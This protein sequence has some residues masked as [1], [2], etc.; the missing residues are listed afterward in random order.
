VISVAIQGGAMR[1]V[2]CVGVIRAL[3]E[4]AYLHEVGTI[5]TSSAGCVAAAVLA[6]QLIDGESP[7]VS[8]MTEE[9]IAK[10]AGPQFINQRRFLKVVDVDYLVRV[11]REVTSVSPQALS[12]RGLTFE[13]AFT[14]AQ[15]G[16]AKYL[17]ISRCASPLEMD[18]ALRATMAIPVLYPTTVN[19]AGRKYVDGGIAD[20]LPLLRAFRQNPKMLLAISSVP[21]GMLGNPAEGREAIILRYAP[22]V[23]SA[24]KRLKL[25]KNPLAGATDSLLS[26]KSFCGVRIVRISPSSLLGHRL[27]IDKGKLHE[28]EARGYEDGVQALNEL[29]ETEAEL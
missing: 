22:G 21:M 23:S 26:L 27:E 15:N 28:L 8:D 9:L 17:D 16:W 5:H 10:L 7:T 11:I 18:Q 3:T 6:S 4:S 24:V 14:D 19:I 1:S 12:R 25:T 2:Y 13:V 29:R 20:P